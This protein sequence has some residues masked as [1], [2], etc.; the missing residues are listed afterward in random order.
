VLP[1]GVVTD[2]K[3]PREA[4]KDARVRSKLKTTGGNRFSRFWTILTIHRTVLRS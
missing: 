1:N 3:I 4:R 2:D